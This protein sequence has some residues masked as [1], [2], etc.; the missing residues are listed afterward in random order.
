MV[1]KANKFIQLADRISNIWDALIPKLPASAL[2][3]FLIVI[4]YSSSSLIRGFSPTLYMLTFSVAFF[5]F[6]GTFYLY[7]NYKSDYS[8]NVFPNLNNCDVRIFQIIYFVSVSLIFIILDNVYYVKPNE[9][10]LLIGIATVSI[11]LQIGLKNE[12]SSKEAF[13]IFLQ[14]LVLATIIRGSSLFLSPF[15]IGVDNHKFHYIH[16]LKIIQTGHLDRSAFHYFYYPCFH[17]MQSIA[18]LVI[19]FSIKIFK[20]INLCNS[21]VLIPVGYLIGSHVCDKKSGLICAL[22]FSLSTMNIF[23]V[24]YSNSKIGGAVLLFFALYILLK[25][26]SSSN[27]K[28]LFLFYICTLSL[29]LWH[30]E[31]SAALLFVLFA[32][33]LTNLFNY[34]QLKLDSLLLLYF[35][36]HISYNMYVS[37]HL[38]QKIVQ[39][40]FFVD[41]SHDSGLIQ[42]FVGHSTGMV[43]MSQLFVAYLGIS[44]PFFFVMYSFFSWIKKNNRMNQFILLSFFAVCLI[45]VVGVFSNNMSLNPARLLTYICLISLIITSLSIFNV[46]SFKSKKSVLL[47]STL[48]FIFSIF[49]VSSYLAADGSEVYNDKIP[50][51]VIFTT[52]SNVAANEFINYNLPDDSTIAIDPTTIC[53][54]RIHKNTVGINEFNSSEYLL[55]NNY[56]IKRLN[57]DLNKQFLPYSNRIYSNYFNTIYLM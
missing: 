43:L 46:F 10:Y 25:I 27:V 53:V 33:S 36:F 18:G 30:P 24:L 16:I 45:P 52:R 42:N 14:I 7:C 11:A 15:H 17:L 54:S 3:F 22:L 5:S 32:Y 44:I 23:L 13:I 39:S 28:Y 47:F 8:V 55:I 6:A 51:G 21:L 29:F 2:I 12:I 41:V 9:Y 57:V 38:F 31:I 19:G 49:S 50:V 40:I 35:I 4:F 1:N 56:Y 26:L 37:T 20:L 34:R 48:I